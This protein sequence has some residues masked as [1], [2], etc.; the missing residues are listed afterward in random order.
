MRSGRREAVLRDAA[1]EVAP[2]Q[3][4]LQHLHAREAA[5]EAVDRLGAADQ[6][7]PPP[8]EPLADP[9]RGLGAVAGGRPLLVRDLGRVDADHAHRLLAA[10][11][12]D[13]ERVAVGDG[14]HGAR[15]PVAAA[16]RLALAV[17]RSAEPAADRE[18][19]RED[20]QAGGAEQDGAEAGAACPDATATACHAAVNDARD[21]ADFSSHSMYD[22]AAFPADRNAM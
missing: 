17:P 19:E 6:A 12:L 14:D 3:R 1:R 8:V 5:P 15:Q 13:V 21:G 7:H 4:A 2:R 9:D 16:R 20:D 18:R 11:Q 10:R 22:I